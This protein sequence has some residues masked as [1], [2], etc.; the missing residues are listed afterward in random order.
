MKKFMFVMPLMA[1]SLLASCNNKQQFTI[2]FDAN[3]GILN[4]ESSIKV[5]DGTLFKDIANKPNA[6][7]DPEGAYTF[8]GWGLTKDTQIPIDD[9]K[10]TN[11]LT[12]YAI[13]T[14]I[15]YAN[16]TFSEESS[17]CI[18]SYNG[19]VL[20]KGVPFKIPAGVDVTLKIESN[21][22]Y[23]PILDK[24]V[25][26][27]EAQSYSFNLVEKEIIVKV[28]KDNTCVIKAE[29]ENTSRGS[30]EAYTWPEINIL[31]KAGLADTCFDVGNTKKVQ[32]QHQTG[33]IY[34][35]VRIIDFNKDK[36]KDG[37]TLGIT[38]EFADLISD[39]NGYSLASL[40][41]DDEDGEDCNF[42]YLNSTIRKNLTGYENGDVMWYEKD[43]ATKS[44]RNQAVLDMLPNDLRSVLKIAKKKVNIKTTG[45][46]VET[47]L[48]DELFL[49]S[50]N[51]MNEKTTS[52]EVGGAYEYYKNAKPGEAD[53][54]RIKQQIKGIDG[55]RTD[56]VSITDNAFGSGG[57]YAGY[58][59]SAAGY[60]GFSW[61][62][63][64]ST[65]GSYV[66]W[67]VGTGG[68][69]YS[70]NVFNDANP[71]APAFCI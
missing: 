62:R 63:S 71:V 6:H 52:A 45:S 33:D 8:N 32:L 24:K 55:A 9:Y 70:Y 22:G 4:G 37:N 64:P 34:Q 38:F 31:S 53:S 42:D 3:G 15:A 58:N 14:P 10:I 17:E 41:Q 69:L 26:I 48:T 51:E 1:V 2:T 35:T 56:S 57:S 18:L 23:F 54:V 43:S 61:L 16:V 29:A 46:W 66:A 19:E 68:S 7:K 28:A 44:S 67:Y 13:Y 5:I 40:W 27:H 21:Q 59:S 36:D 39:E 11:D 12:V 49:L 25:E 30:L 60:G 20:T 50:A 65:D 47:D